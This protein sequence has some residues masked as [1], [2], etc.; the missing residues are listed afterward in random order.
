MLKLAHVSVIDGRSS[1]CVKNL[2]AEV[3]VQL[4]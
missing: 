2:G 1:Q 4:L 3:C